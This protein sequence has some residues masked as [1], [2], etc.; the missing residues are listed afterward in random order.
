MPRGFH[1]KDNDPLSPLYLQAFGGLEV[2]PVDNIEGSIKIITK[3]LWRGKLG[4]ILFGSYCYHMY[5]KYLDFLVQGLGTLVV[6]N[7]YV[8]WSK[9]SNLEVMKKKIGENSEDICF[10]T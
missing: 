10:K 5:A 4:M 7:L 1:C 8:S 2:G 6:Q 9:R 3:F